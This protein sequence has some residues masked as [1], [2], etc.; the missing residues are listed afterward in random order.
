MKR[1]YLFLFL[2]ST[3]FLFLSSCDKIDADDIIW[4]EGST[5]IEPLYHGNHL[6][7]M[8]NEEDLCGKVKETSIESSYGEEVASMHVYN[9]AT[10]LYVYVH[11]KKGYSLVNSSIYSSLGIPDI[12]ALYR[13]V[14]YHSN[15]T[16]EY[17]FTYSLE[18]YEDDCLNI[19]FRGKFKKEGKS[20]R[21]GYKGRKYSRGGNYITAWASGLDLG[22][23]SKC[24]GYSGKYS[25]YCIQWCDQ[26]V[27]M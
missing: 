17:C 1:V 13:D 25:E 22:S 20:C 11:V 12:R 2:L 26:I 21:R 14:I 8:P 4:D 23:R 3:A 16:V 6:A 18:G 24:R 7:S 5:A 19:A 10:T 27:E 9:D 15:N